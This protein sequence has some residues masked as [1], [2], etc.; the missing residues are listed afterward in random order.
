[1]LLENARASSSTGDLWVS[2]LDEPRQCIERG[3][4]VS[5]GV[6]PYKLSAVQVGQPEAVIAVVQ[7]AIPEP[8][9]IVWLCNIQQETSFVLKVEDSQGTSS[10]IILCA[11]A[12]DSVSA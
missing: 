4:T 5:G 7:D 6:P 1:M 3:V 12:T 8:C 2:T 10:A 9:E 11:A